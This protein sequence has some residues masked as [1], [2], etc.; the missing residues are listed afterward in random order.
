MRMSGINLKDGINTAIEA[1]IASPFVNLSAMQA[2]GSKEHV[3][4]TLKD[5]KTGDE[6]SFSF[7]YTND[8]VRVSTNEE[9][10]LVDTKKK[11]DVE[12]EVMKAFYKNVLQG[13]L[14]GTPVTHTQVVLAAM[15]SLLDRPDIALLQ[16]ESDFNGIKSEV[17]WIVNGQAVK[18]GEGVILEGQG[19]IGSE[20]F[21]YRMIAGEQNR[22][23]IEG[24]LG[25]MQIRGEGYL[26]GNSAVLKEQIGDRYEMIRKFH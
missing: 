11:F 7:T 4:V 13:T 18:N 6:T 17:A 22:F 2:V 26:D 20:K 8:G 23:K 16:S 10:K 3:D 21:S 9:I 1:Y 24:K 25:N 19:D 15:D 14:F 12:N 5:K